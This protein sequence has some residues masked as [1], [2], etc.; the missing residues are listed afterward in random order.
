MTEAAPRRILVVDDEKEIV[1]ALQY[2][3]EEESYEV[4]TAVTVEDALDKVAEGP[5]DAVLLDVTMGETDG[6][7]VARKLRSDSATSHVPIVIL[8]GV[9]MSI[10]REQFTDY[11]LFVNKGA[12]LGQ[13]VQQLDLLLGGTSAESRTHPDV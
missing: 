12:D 1:E 3:L 9:D 11:D 4:V 8:T 6:L 2:T 10:V 5:F 13:L 7:D